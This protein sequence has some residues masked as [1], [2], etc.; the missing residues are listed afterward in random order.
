MQ[1]ESWTRELVND[2]LQRKDEGGFDLALKLLGALF[3]AS[4]T[5]PSGD[6]Q[7]QITARIPA[8][9]CEYNMLVLQ[10]LSGC[11]APQ[12]GNRTRRVLLLPVASFSHRRR[13]SAACSFSY[14]P[15]GCG[16]SQP[17]FSPEIRNLNTS[18]RPNQITRFLHS[19]EGST[20]I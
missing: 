12:V 8:Q 5:A 11:D 18:A 15:S 1:D 14:G 20:S 6:C 16:L 7:P 10:R 4:P 19:I 2:I 3:A 13:M 17:H 9:Q